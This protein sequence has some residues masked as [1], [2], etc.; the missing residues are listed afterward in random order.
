MPPR[1]GHKGK[2]AK[3]AVHKAFEPHIP[4]VRASTRKVC[5]IMGKNAKKTK[6]FST[7]MLHVF[8]LSCRVVHS[9]SLC[10]YSARFCCLARAIKFSIFLDSPVWHRVRQFPP[11]VRSPTILRALRRMS[12]VM[13]RLIEC[14][15]LYVLILV[16]LLVLKKLDRIQI[17]S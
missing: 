4:C 3:A 8:M 10:A 9:H 12:A 2:K 7:T 1:R 6:P 16:T 14:A 15:V 11:I 17:P 13:N 5:F